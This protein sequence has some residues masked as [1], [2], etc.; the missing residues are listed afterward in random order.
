MVWADGAMSTVGLRTVCAS[1]VK[2]WPVR[3]TCLVSTE[4]H[5]NLQR[6]LVNPHGGG[7]AITTRRAGRAVPTERQQQTAVQPTW[8]STGSSRRCACRSLDG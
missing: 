6:P 2:P 3:T 5:S 8:R 1:A 4:A 7:P